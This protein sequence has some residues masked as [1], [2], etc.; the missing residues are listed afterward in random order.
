MKAEIGKVY[1]FVSC[2]RQGELCL[3]LSRMD[4]LMT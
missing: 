2:T 1:N 4:E 3:K